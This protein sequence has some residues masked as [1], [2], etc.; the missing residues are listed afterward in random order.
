MNTMNYKKNDNRLMLQL[1][2]DFN[3]NAVRE[4]QNLLSN[5]EELYIDLAKARFVNSEAVIFLHRL[6]KNGR[7]IRLK[8]P[9]KIFFEVLQ[10]LG[11]HEEWDLKTIIER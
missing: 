7:T 10:I 2:G 8:N 3:L 1:P 11:L 5:G 4:I 6:I 9:P